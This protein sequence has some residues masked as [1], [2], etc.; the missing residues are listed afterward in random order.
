MCHDG[1]FVIM[2]RE[3][4]E[5]R[6]LDSV[7][8]NGVR[9]L[10]GSARIYFYRLCIMTVYDSESNEEELRTFTGSASHRLRAQ[11]ILQNRP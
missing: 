11:A 5:R 7:M 1:F 8:S 4:V 6:L 9:R 10:L 3:L 2:I